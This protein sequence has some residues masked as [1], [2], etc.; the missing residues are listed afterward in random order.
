[1][2]SC[3]ACQ[4]TYRPEDIDTALG[5]AHCDACGTVSELS[6]RTRRVDRPVRAAPASTRWKTVD[7]NALALEYRWFGLEGVFMLLFTTFWCGSIFTMISGIAVSDGVFAAL[8]MLAV[9][10]VWI[11]VGL[12]YYSLATLLNTTEIF[13][14]DGRLTVR[15]GPV[16]WWGS[17]DVRID[18]IDQFY[19]ERSGVRVNKQPR[20]NLALMSKSG[21]GQVLVRLI[22]TESEALWL[23]DT[24]ERK[25]AIVDRPVPGEVSK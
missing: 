16:P 5:V 7:E 24:I 6:A 22:A 1:M 10:H 20:W 2:L 19:V 21:T 17:R 8:P 25:L 3:A 18:E 23:E 4:Q 12:A 14:E 11:G 13:A 9:P 15:H